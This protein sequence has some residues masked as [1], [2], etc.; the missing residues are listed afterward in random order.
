MY[1]TKCEVSQKGKFM[2]CVQSNVAMPNNTVAFN[3]R[4]QVMTN[5]S[6]NK[7]VINNLKGAAGTGCGIMGLYGAINHQTALAAMG[8]IM[9]AFCAS[10]LSNKK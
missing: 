6:R 10:L 4:R 1:R 7:K 8:I 3:G 2:L 9:A 5:L